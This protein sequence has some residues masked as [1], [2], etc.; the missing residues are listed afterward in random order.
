MTP[1]ER[2]LRDAW[3]AELW[4]TCRELPRHVRDLERARAEVTQGVEKPA[5][6]PGKAA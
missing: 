3:I 2:A 1:A 4:P 5:D 6:S